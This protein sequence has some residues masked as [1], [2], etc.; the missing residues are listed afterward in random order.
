MTFSLRRRNDARA[1]TGLTSSTGAV[2]LSAGASATGARQNGL[3][4]CLDYW[5]RQRCGLRPQGKVEEQPRR[6]DAES[7]EQQLERHAPVAIV[8]LRRPRGDRDFR[9]RGTRAVDEVRQR[10][11]EVRGL[12]VALR[13]V[14]FHRL[15][16]DRHQRRRCLGADLVDRARVRGDDLLERL[17]DRAAIEGAAPCEQFIQNRAEREDVAARVERSRPWPVR[18]TCSSACRPGDAS[19]CPCLPPVPVTMR[20]RNRATWA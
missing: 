20:C 14:A 2:E 18:A 8:G 16:H 15:A 3:R 6:D 10:I 5:R 4:H 7:A 17:V 11:A 12:L 9:H 19:T 13:R 1:S